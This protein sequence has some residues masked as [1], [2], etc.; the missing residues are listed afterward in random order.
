MAPILVPCLVALR[1]EFDLVNPQRDHASD[2]WIGNRAHA[3]QVSDHNGDES[4]RTPYED[5]DL[6]DEVHGLD[7]DDTGPW[8]YSGWFDDKVNHIVAEHRA[9]RDNRLQ[10]VIRNGRIASRSW[11]WEWRTYEGQNGHFEHAHF[12]ARYTTEQES[13]TS[14]W[15]VHVSLT[16]TDLANVEARAKTAAAAALVEA[17][18]RIA[19]ATMGFDPGDANDD[20]DPDWPGVDDPWNAGETIA[21]GTALTEIMRRQ[22][23]LETKLDELLQLLRTTHPGPVDPPAPP[24]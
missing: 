23:E 18:P 13:D 14:P 19:R 8:P 3:L 6:V 24:A 5:A 20:G 16:P 22:A 17:T 15:G 7:I 12:S 2:G 9:G 4:G 1:R 10:N 21:P 11:G